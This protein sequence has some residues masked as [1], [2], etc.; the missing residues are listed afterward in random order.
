MRKSDKK[1]DNQLRKILTDVC[2]QALKKIE[3]FE[4]LTHTV[5]FSN[6]PNSLKVTCVFDTNENLARYLD[7]EQSSALLSLVSAELKGLNIKLKDVKKHLA[8]DTEENCEQQHN[9]NWAIRL[10]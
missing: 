10:S 3:G 5:N 4:W 2:A 9:G 7:S 1:L 8:Y 6:Y